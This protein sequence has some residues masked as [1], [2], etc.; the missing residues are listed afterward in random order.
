MIVEK[1]FEKEDKKTFLLKPDFYDFSAVSINS[2]LIIEDKEACLIDPGGKKTFYELK[3]TVDEILEKE[4]TALS[5]VIGTHQDPDVSSSINLWIESYNVNFFLPRVWMRFVAHLEIE[6]LDKITPIPDGGMDL[7][8]ANG[9][10]LNLLPAHFLHSSGNVHIYHSESKI[11][12]SGDFGAS[13]SSDIFVKDFQSVV[14]SLKKFHE[15]YIPSSKALNFYIENILKKL[16]INMIVPQHGSVYSK[17]NIEDLLNFLENLKCGVDI[18]D[19]IYNGKKSLFLSDSIIE[20]IYQIRNLHDVYI[21]NLKENKID[22]INL[23]HKNCDFGK[24]FY[25]YIYP[26]SNSKCCE[27]DSIICKTIS[28]IEDKHKEFHLFLKKSL[29][30]KRISKEELS[31]L[32]EISN[33]LKELIDNL[34]DVVI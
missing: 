23:S 16:D 28:E 27:K 32:N 18:L 24:I 19:E 33:G 2:L 21:L 15:R 20:K 13:E 12:F 6:N 26:L 14:P 22:R 34:I 4:N 8:F 30:D 25:K 11:L 9:S 31:K 5:F 10:I 7:V 29:E 3:Y 17:E 1:L